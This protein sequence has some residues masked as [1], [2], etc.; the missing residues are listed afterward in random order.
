MT[1]RQHHL[2]TDEVQRLI[3]RYFEGE[4][5]GVAEVTTKAAEKTTVYTADGIYVGNST[6]GLAKGLYIVNG[7]KYIVK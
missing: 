3:S 5:T 4:T 2:H 7:K 6:K 1:Q